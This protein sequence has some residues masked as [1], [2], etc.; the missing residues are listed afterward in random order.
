MDD[1]GAEPLAEQATDTPP[2][3]DNFDRKN[4]ESQ[5]LPALIPE[6]P[7]APEHQRK[8]EHRC[9]PDQ[10]P[11]WKIF[12]EVGAF[13][14]GLVFAGIYRGQL[15]AMQGQLAQM[16]RDSQESSK[17]FQAQ[18]QHFDAGLGRTDMLAIHAGE[19][20]T[21]SQNF[22]DAS[23]IQAETGKKSLQA[24][25]DN[26]HEDQ[27]P[28]VGLMGSNH[29]SI[30]LSLNLPIKSEI[31]IQNFGKTPAIHE[32]SVNKLLTRPLSVPLPSM[33]NYSI[34]DA[35]PTITLMPTATVSGKISSDTG[36]DIGNNFVLDQTVLD[37][38]QQ[39]VLQI[40][41]YGSIWYDD[42]FGKSHRTDY[43][44]LYQPKSHG[45]TACDSHNYAD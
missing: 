14:L 35:G 39:G 45:F 44:L 34:V 40:Y 33:D 42:A 31:E 8:S 19:Q 12:L 41:L 2:K 15:N 3:Q 4:P 7:L 30:E 11:A 16:Q 20:A 25:I 23:K 32:A 24:T 36:S 17:Q 21:A 10:T 27:R 5:S 29:T 26:F 13:A 9:K 22:A 38:I 37:A 28:W 6:V 1:S 43:C 18:I